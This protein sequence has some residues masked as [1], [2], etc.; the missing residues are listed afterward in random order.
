MYMYGN[1]TC[2]KCDVVDQ[3][4]I[5]SV[6]WVKSTCNYIMAILLVYM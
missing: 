6:K 4:I 5:Q 3:F 2:S 1:S